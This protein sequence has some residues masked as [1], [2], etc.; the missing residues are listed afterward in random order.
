MFSLAL[1]TLFVSRISVTQ[2]LN[3]CYTKF[4]AK[5]AHGPRKKPFDFRGNPDHVTSGS[6]IRAGNGTA[7]AWVNTALTHSVARKNCW[8]NAM[9]F[10]HSCTRPSPGMQAATAI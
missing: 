7:T 2:K 1:V 9:L 10:R 5:V 3:R 4:G 8:I 6:A